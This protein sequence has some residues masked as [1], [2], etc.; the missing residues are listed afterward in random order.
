MATCAHVV[1]PDFGISYRFFQ[2]LM[3]CNED[4]ISELGDFFNV[5]IDSFK[6]GNKLTD[7]ELSISGFDIAEK[8]LSEKLLAHEEQGFLFVVVRKLKD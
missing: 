4:S 1:F 6:R 2:G 3:S 5:E 7:A 8:I